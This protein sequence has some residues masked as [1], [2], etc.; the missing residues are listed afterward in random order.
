MVLW[1]LV[2]SLPW[3]SRP[4]LSEE[5]LRTLCPETA[6]IFLFFLPEPRRGTAGFLPE[7]LCFSAQ[8]LAS[9]FVLGSGTSMP[10]GPEAA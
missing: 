3:R 8:E 2:S 9:H 10:G 4:V 1:G 5:Y 6:W 7:T